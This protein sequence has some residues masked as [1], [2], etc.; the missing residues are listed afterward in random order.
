MNCPGRSEPVPASSET[1][2]AAR[3]DGAPADGESQRGPP[4][5]PARGEGGQHLTLKGLAAEGPAVWATP[6]RQ[7]QPWG[8]QPAHPGTLRHS[9][10]D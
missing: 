7:R 10:Q 4:S 1:S 5:P 3:A 8:Q 2:A 9:K 6:A